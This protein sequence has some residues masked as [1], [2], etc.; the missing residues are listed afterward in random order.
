MEYTIS[1]V[2]NMNFIW[3]L[4]TGVP[5][6]WIN[7][8]LSCLLVHNGFGVPCCH[9]SNSPGMSQLYIYCHILSTCSQLQ[10]QKC[11]GLTAM[12]ISCTQCWSH[13]SKEAVPPPSSLQFIYHPCR[14]S[15]RQP[16]I[17]M[18][19][20]RASASRIDIAS[21]VAIS[22]ANATIIAMQCES[23]HTETNCLSKMTFS[24]N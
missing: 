12:Q 16:P 2:K 23:I 4:V 9:T 11:W 24:S 13:C 7:W 5:L 22:V 10:I 15:W 19:I 3:E 21:K 6:V 14:C 20:L 18:S 17:S 1:Q 8:H